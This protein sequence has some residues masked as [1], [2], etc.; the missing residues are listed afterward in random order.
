MQ[1]NLIYTQLVDRGLKRG[2]IEGYKEVHH[3]IPKCMGGSNSIDN[4]VAL[5]PEEHY[6]AHLLLVKIY[7]NIYKLLYAV[8]IMAAGN[9]IQG[10][11]RS[12]NKM[13]GWI[14]RR[15]V[16]LR[17]A[18]L[19]EIKKC[20][21]CDTLFES[22]KCNKRV[23][24]GTKCRRKLGQLRAIQIGKKEHN[25]IVCN[26][27]F[28][29]FE[30]CNRKFCSQDCKISSQKIR[31]TKICI[32]CSKEYVGTPCSL[33]NRQYCSRTCSVKHRI[34]SVL[35]TCPKCAKEIYIDSYLVKTKRYCTRECRYTT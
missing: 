10:Q 35:W 20:R 25:C 28:L 19:H 15:F 30:C 29:E 6:L 33:K 7:P 31:I 27:V 5:T 21:A 34:T 8:S 16:G 17:D 11:C 14:K 9:R 12:T 22:Y 26:N 18:G 13:Y 24:C 3:I 32:G 4:L 2:V 1:Y 23:Y